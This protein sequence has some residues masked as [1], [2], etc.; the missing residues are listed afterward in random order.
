MK[1]QDFLEQKRVPFTTLEH[2]TTYTAQQLAAS[3]H[4][5]SAWGIGGIHMTPPENPATPPGVP[6]PYPN[7]SFTGA[8][9]PGLTGPGR[10]WRGKSWRGKTWRGKTW[11]RG[12]RFR[13]HRV[14][15]VRA[16]P[17]LRRKLR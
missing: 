2:D 6:V 14:K 4:T 10:A 3:T 5:A 8:G 16:R 9:K 11:H 7:T 12:K 15:R 13:L 17:G 1:I